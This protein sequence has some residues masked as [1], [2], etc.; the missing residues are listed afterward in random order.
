LMKHNLLYRYYEN[1][2]LPLLYILTGATAYL[3]L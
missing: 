1:P 3:D 2:G